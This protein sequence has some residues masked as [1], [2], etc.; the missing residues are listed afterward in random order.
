MDYR[1]PPPPSGRAGLQPGFGLPEDLLSHL[2]NR[3]LTYNGYTG[4]WSK[5]DHP[6]SLCSTPPPGFTF[7]KSKSAADSCNQPGAVISR[8]ED[9]FEAMTDCIIGEKNE[10]VIQLKSRSRTKPQ[11]DDS[12]A[13]AAKKQSNLELRA[14]TFPSRSPQ[15]AWKFTALLRI[16]ELCHEALVTGTVTT[17]RDIYYRDP[18][19]FMKQAVVDRYVNDLAYTL[20]VQRD[21]LNVVAAAKGLVV[22][23][24]TITKNDN[25]VV[26]YGLE[27]EVRLFP[28]PLT[29]DYGLMG[30]GCAT[31][32]TLAASEYWMRSITGPG[33]IITAKG[34]PDIQTRQFLHLL[35]IQKLD[36]PIYALVDFDPD[37][38]GIMSTYKHGSMALAH[39]SANLSTPS[40]KWL[41]V[42]SSDFLQ[43]SS[44]V[45]G[46]LKLSARD[47]RVATKMLEKGIFKEDGSEVE[48]RRELQVMLMLN[49]KAEIQI[50]GN[51]EK[52]GEWLDRNLLEGS[53]SI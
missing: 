39:E 41:G 14:I 6:V 5:L 23:P 15:E 32:R 4:T 46:L 49:V 16:L 13:T 7:Q 25:S 37:G 11:A 50:L 47:R 31:F 48:W 38:I 42:R 28:V 34:Y 19:L 12:G 35:F 3:E 21:A 29:I 24:F 8:I 51:A 52:L 26:D 18:E 45:Q 33:I 53:R 10:L 17:K 2:P 36:I 27:H 1:P 44:D 22:G 43:T 20:G 30:S 40:I 9:V